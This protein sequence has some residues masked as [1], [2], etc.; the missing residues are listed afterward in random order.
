MEDVDK[1]EEEIA[2]WA[3]KPHYV[4]D[5]PWFDGQRRLVNAKGEEIGKC[6]HGIDLF[7]DCETCPGE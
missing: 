5:N 3:A 2:T 1:L 4:I 6:V 7:D